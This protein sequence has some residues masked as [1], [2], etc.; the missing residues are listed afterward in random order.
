MKHIATAILLVV[1]Y[2]IWILTDAPT[3]KERSQI[4][5]PAPTV[6]TAPVVAQA[7]KESQPSV[8]Q[9]SIADRVHQVSA[10]IEKLSSQL[11]EVDQELAALGYPEVMLDERL[12]E[13]D[14]ERI[15]NK[16]LTASRIH[17][18]MT[19]LTLKRIDLQAEL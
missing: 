19:M 3:P 12:N 1:G 18:V 7:L 6:L 10:E 14:R 5:V 11:A 17:N 16:V 15:V 4:G 8:S 13:A 2:S 9:P